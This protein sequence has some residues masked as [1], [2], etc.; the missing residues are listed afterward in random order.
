MSDAVAAAGADLGGIT[1]IVLGH[2]DADHRGTAPR[3]A[4]PV[5]CH[6]AERPAAESSSAVRDY[7]D[8]G[9]LSGPASMVLPKLLRHWDGG[10]VPIAGTVAEGD[11]V[12]GFRVIHLP[13]HAPGLIGLF[14]ESDRLA[15]CSDCIY[16]IDVQTGLRSRP[17]V[18][19]PAFNLDTEQARASIVKL[20]EHEPSVVWPGHANPVRGDVRAQLLDVARA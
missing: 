6:E 12:A 2:A 9:K 3:L 4:A 5:Y 16:T 17:R 8:L 10:A 7:W 1:R 18:P 14:R 11:D 15:L 13:G 19:H 20:A